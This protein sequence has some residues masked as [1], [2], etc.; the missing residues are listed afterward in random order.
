MSLR[1]WVM[2]LTGGDM[3]V[4]AHAKCVCAGTRAKMPSLCLMWSIRQTQLFSPETE[5]LKALSFNGPN[6]LL[7]LPSN[8]K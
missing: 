2:S 1:K 4:R 3:G 8:L 7:F 5:C 6:N